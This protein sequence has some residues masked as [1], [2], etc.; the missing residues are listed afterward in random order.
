M[1][2]THEQAQLRHHLSEMRQGV[3]G[4]G[5]DFAIE[6]RDLDDKIA[7]LGTLTAQEAKYALRDIES[8]LSRLGASIDA[9]MHRLPGQVAGGFATVGRGISNSTARFAGATRDAVESAGHRAKESTKNA[10]ASAAGVNRKPMKEWHVPSS[11]PSSD[12]T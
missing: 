11:D 8:D 5:R 1:P 12:D 2:P 9:E 4:L 6:F 3:G 10:L 7:R